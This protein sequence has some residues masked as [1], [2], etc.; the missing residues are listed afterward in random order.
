VIGAARNI[1]TTL[2]AIALARRLV[3]DGSVV[4]VDLAFASPN[5]S[6]ISDD[7]NAP[8]IA[9]RIR[10]EAAF[11]EIITRDRFSRVHLIATGHFD[12]DGRAM[13]VSDQLAGTL[14]AL[15]RSYDYVLID[16]GAASDNAIGQIARLAPYAVMIVPTTDD[17][18]VMVSRDRLLSAG[19]ADVTVMAGQRGR[20]D[21]AA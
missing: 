21:I 8:G 18:A 11:G 1:G 10:G 13:L 15:G 19:F 5:L 3:Q 16:A 6:V 7:P 17:P 14:E 2:S 20:A 4:L 12:D 9:D